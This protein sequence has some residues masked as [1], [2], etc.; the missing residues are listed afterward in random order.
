MTRRVGFVTR[1][2]CKL[3]EQALPAVMEL[4]NSKGWPIEIVDVDQSD[5]AG[6]F[7]DRVPVVL[8]DGIEVLAGRFDDRDLR[9]ALR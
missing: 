5:L 7:G 9:K 1:D 4:A 2:G 8:L 3:C 6:E